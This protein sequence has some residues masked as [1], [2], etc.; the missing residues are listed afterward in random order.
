MGPVLP[1]DLG[2]RRPL[3]LGAVS[4]RPLGKPERFLVLG[5]GTCPAYGL[6]A[7]TRR[8][9]RNRRCRTG[10]RLG[11]AGMGRTRRAWWGSPGFR[12]HPWW[13]GWS[14]PRAARHEG[15]RQA[16]DPSALYANGR[17]KGAVVVTSTQRFGTTHADVQPL[18]HAR[19]LTPLH[20][21]LPVKPDPAK[22]AADAPRGTAP[23]AAVT[24]REVTTLRRGQQAR[25][26]E[27]EQHSVAGAAAAEEVTRTPPRL[28][29]ANDFAAPASP[30]RMDAAGTQ[31]L[32]VPSPAPPESGDRGRN[33]S[34]PLPPIQH[35]LPGARQMP[36]AIHPPHLDRTP[37]PA[38][39]PAPA[40]PRDAVR[41]QP[42]VDDAKRGVRNGTSGAAVTSSGR[43]TATMPFNERRTLQPR[44]D[45]NPA[46]GMQ[47]RERDERMQRRD[48]EEGESSTRTNN[49]QPHG[50]AQE[51]RESPQPGR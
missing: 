50:H 6:C 26:E 44:G 51:R 33:P 10:C 47:S 16:V 28:D 19:S 43:T 4:L 30:R 21:A 49:R 40:T 2:G 27:R 34:G 8:L 42:T 15:R 29:G 35:R 11:C 22:L 7:C 48:R 13:G 45:E 37:P 9:F 32:A 31:V 14:G 1:V 23:P 18:Q 17:I 46:P 41:P 3:G 5:A 25:R 12:G 20:G 38:G 24:I 39:A 36:G